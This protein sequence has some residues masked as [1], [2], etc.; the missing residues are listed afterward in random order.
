MQRKLTEFNSEY[1]YVEIAYTKALLMFDGFRQSVGDKKFFGGLQRYYSRMKFRNANVD[2]LI[3]CFKKSGCDG[4][5][6][7]NSWIDGKVI[8]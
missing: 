5:G 7:F 2:D 1:E 4:Q 3:Y 8:V 6:Y